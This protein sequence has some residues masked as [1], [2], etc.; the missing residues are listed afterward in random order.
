MDKG[1]C[2]PKAIITNDVPLVDL[3]RVM[4]LLRGP[5]DETKVHVVM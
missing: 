2:D 3:P 4:D 1:H 5:N